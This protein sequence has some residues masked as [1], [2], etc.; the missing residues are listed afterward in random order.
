M[1]LWGVGHHLCLCVELPFHWPVIHESLAGNRATGEHALTLHC[2]LTWILLKEDSLCHW[3]SDFERDRSGPRVQGHCHMVPSV[4]CAPICAF[5]SLAVSV[6]LHVCRYSF[7]VFPALLCSWAAC[8]LFGSVSNWL[9]FWFS[10]PNGVWK[11]PAVK[12]VSFVHPLP[13]NL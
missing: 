3:Q 4:Y 8:R 10:G 11:S 6:T 12:R 1:L 7:S 2:G 13:V 9:P 5:I